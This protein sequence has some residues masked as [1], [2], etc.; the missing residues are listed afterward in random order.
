MK[1][2]DIGVIVTTLIIVT[3]SCSLAFFAARVVGEPKDINLVAKNVSITFTDTSSIADTIISP[4]WNSVKTFVITNNSKSEYKFNIAIKNLLNTFVT[5]GYLQYKITSTNNGYNMTEYKD[6]PKASIVTDTTLAY[7]VLI[8]A[9]VTQTYTVAFRYLNDKEIN[10]AD[11]MGKVLKGT[12]F[13]TEGSSLKLVKKILEDNPTISER[14]DF[15]TP[16]TTNTINTLY[17]ALENNI[18]V[19]Y[20]AGQDTENTPINNWVKFGKNSSNQDLYWRIIRTNSDGGIRLLYHGTSTTAEDAYIG[21]SKFNT[22]GDPAYMS[23]MYGENFGTEEIDRSNTNNSIVKVVV[24][25]WYESN[26]INYTK[27][28]STTA[29]YCNDREYMYGDD[30]VFWYGKYSSSNKPSYNCTDIRDAFS[31]DNTSAKLKYPIALMTADEMAFAGGKENEYGKAWYHLNSLNKSSTG[32]SS[33]WTMTPKNFEGEYSENSLYSCDI[34]STEQETG[35]IYG[36][37]TNTENSVRPVISL[38]S[39][40]LW[41]SGNGAADSPYEIVLN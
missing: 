32:T 5:E 22:S 3:I 33:W 29:V 36:M 39:D 10:Q 16:F 11:D 37:Y 13:I 23:Y 20:F 40:V 15:T 12:L 6:I 24:D 35:R 8:P 9:G 17:K 1:K 41:S 27:Y 4:G 34:S 25:S 2:I 38:K 26:L 31:V 21:T 7:S 18:D 30:V 14:T 28:L 19:Y